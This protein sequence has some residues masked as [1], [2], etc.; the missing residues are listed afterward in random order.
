MKIDNIDN[1]KDFDFGKTSRDYAK[2]R[3]IYPQIFYDCFIKNGIGLK[4]QKILD[5]G[6]GTGVI[7]RFLY[8]YGASF[9][10]TD[11]SAEQIEMAKEL[12]KGMGIEY[13]AK[14]AEELDFPDNF[15]DCV[16][17]CQCIWYLNGEILRNTLKR[18]LKPNGKIIITYMGWLPEESKI[19]NMSENLILKYNPNWTGGG[20][21][22]KY[23]YIPNELR[24]SFKLE[25]EEI[26]DALVPFTIDTWAGRIRACRGVGGMMDKE[27]M[28]KFNIDHIEKLKE[29]TSNEFNIEHYINYALL[30]NEK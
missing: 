24:E 18:I 5:I 10:G 20:D 29:M 13:Y 15:F 28:D 3:D 21:K 12:S 30:I 4:G 2:Y 16:T 22:R 27:T 8:N 19:A 14:S 1:G 23:G 26:I 6:T 9:I 25:K 11:I 17:I 7:P